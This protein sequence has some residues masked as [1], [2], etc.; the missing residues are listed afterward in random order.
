MIVADQQLE[1]IRAQRHSMRLVG[2]WGAC[3]EVACFV[4]HKYGW[5]R[6]DGVYALPDGRPIFLHSW[7]VMPDGWI[8]DG[9]ADQF[10]E[11][12]NVA[13]LS[14]EVAVPRYREKFTAA[15]NPQT[16][17][18]L[19]KMPYAGLPDQMFWDEQEGSKSLVP[20]WWLSDRETYLSWFK[21]G[22]AVYPK[23]GIMRERY[24][25]RGYD[26]AGLE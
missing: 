21:R 14:P 1:E 25:D 26:V 24:R 10:G 8:V 13:V 11:G 20:G 15:H 17:P 22:A 18:W 4:E 16:T 6:V 12:L 5:R 19:A 9:T 2:C 23:F 7:N 3:F